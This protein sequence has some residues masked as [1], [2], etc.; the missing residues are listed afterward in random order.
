MKIEEK[1][2]H[3]I[4]CRHGKPVAEIIPWKKNEK[5]PLKQNPKLKK[6]TFYEDPTT[7]LDEEDWPEENR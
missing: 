6:V 5:D 4:I 2:E 7:P 1:H 3:V